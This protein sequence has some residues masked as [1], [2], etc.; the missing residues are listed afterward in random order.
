M[1]SAVLDHRNT[2]SSEDNII[3]QK[4]IETRWFFPGTVPSE[5]GRWFSSPLALT[6][7]PRVDT[8]LHT[9]GT[10]NLG[11]K[12]REG[13]I[14]L[15]QRIHQLGSHT[16]HPHV[17][18]IVESWYKWGFP[19]NA[20]DSTLEMHPAT[21]IPITKERRLRQYQ[22]VSEG[23]IK[24]IP[25]WLFPLQRSSIE[26][27]NIL[28]KNDPWWS[29]CFEVIGTDIDLFAVLQTTARVAFKRSGFPP[30]FAEQSCSY[31]QW[32]DQMCT[33]QEP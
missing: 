25:A 28:F 1:H 2:T 13:R 9:P 8:Y 23:R 3:M 7:P 19:L 24:A 16:F 26:I 15:K 10:H 6:Q 22:V 31:P 18:G 5:V 14:E 20:A 4:S 12:L 33:A 30:L 21:W 11:V 17:T 32:I 27:S 29:L